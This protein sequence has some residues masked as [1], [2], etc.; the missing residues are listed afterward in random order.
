MHDPKTLHELGVSDHAPV[1]YKVSFWKS[2]PQDEQP[3]ARAVFEN[4]RFKILHDLHV[5]A[6][7]LDSLTAIERRQTHKWII[8]ECAMI[9]RDEVTLIDAK[10]NFSLNNVF[11]ATARAVWTNNH[12]L[13]KTLLGASS[14][15]REH[16]AIA[17]TEVRLLNPGN[18]PRILQE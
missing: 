8:R 13:A 2:L 3:I 1:E 5:K 14:L 18:S 16:M 7:Q 9:V 6:A 10:S 15:A 4:N 11:T 12:R 17:G